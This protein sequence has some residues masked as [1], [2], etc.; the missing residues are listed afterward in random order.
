MAANENFGSMKPHFGCHPGRI[1]AH[2]SSD[3]GHHYGNIFATEQFPIVK[4]AAHSTSVNVAVDGMQRFERGDSIG[5]L[6]RPEIAGVPKL[7]NVGKKLHKRLIKRTVRVRKYPDFFHFLGFE[8]AFRVIIR[9]RPTT[10]Y[11]D[12]PMS[13][14]STI[15]AWKDPFEV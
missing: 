10:L 12:L 1:M 14:F 8:R 2:I 6:D 13:L 7:V 5:H 11:G 3:V 4:H 9:P 15:F